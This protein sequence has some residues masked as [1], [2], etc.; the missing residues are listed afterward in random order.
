MP[1]HHKIDYVEFSAHD[2]PASKAFLP[3]SLAR[4]LR[5][6]VLNIRPLPMLVLRVDSLPIILTV[7][8]NMV[9]H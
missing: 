8:P 9:A 6:S 4:R 1:A 3:K 5:I 7:A 2:I